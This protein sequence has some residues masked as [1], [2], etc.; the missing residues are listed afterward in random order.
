MNYTSALHI[1]ACLILPLGVAQAAPEVAPKAPVNL[2]PRAAISASGQF[3]ADYQ[4]R[5]VA[6]G[7]VPAAESHD[8]TGRAWCLSQANAA[9]ARLVFEWPAPVT[10]AEIV[11]YGRTAWLTNENFRQVRVLTEDAP[12]AI[13]EADL[14]PGH[15]PQHIRLPAPLTTRKLMLVF[16]RVD[17]G[18]NPGA[19]EICLFDAPISDAAL[20]RLIAPGDAGTETV[21]NE[22]PALKARLERGEFGFTKTLVVQRRPIR[23]SHVYT[24]HCEGLQPGGG[25][26]VYDL[27]SSNLTQLVDAAE[28]VVLD[29]DLSYDGREVLFSWM[30]D[31]KRFQVYRIGID[32]RG[33]KQLTDGDTYNFNACWLPDG[34]IAFLSTRR[35]AYAY[36]WSS[37]AGILHRMERDGEQVR[38]LSANYLND[39]TPSVLNDGRIVYSR[40]EYV[41]RPAIPIQSLW[42]INPDGTGLRAYYGNRVLS[43]A[44]FMEPRAVPGSQDVLCIM[45]AHNGPCRGAIGRLDRRFGE[46][47]QEA[48]RNLTPE[49]N[50]G[51]VDAGNGNAIR[52][53]YES[54]FPLDERYLFISKEGSLLIRDQEG[55]E[56]ALVLPRNSA[57]GWFNA[58]PVRPRER[59]PVVAGNIAPRNRETEWATVYVQDV[60]EGLGPS[61]QRGE[62]TEIRVVQEVPKPVGVNPDRRLFGFQFPVVS[63]GAT[64]AP[65]KIWGSAKVEA[66]GSASFRVPANLPVYFMALDAEGR[67]V[68]RMRSFV[69]LAPGEVQGCVGCHEHRGRTARLDARPAATARRAQEL[70]PPDWGVKGFSYAEVVQPVLD[71]HCIECHDARKR[72]KNVDLT[73]DKTD[74]F[75]VSYEC[76]ARMGTPAEDAHRGGFDMASF[77]SPYT[78]WIPTYNGTEQNILEIRPRTWGSPASKLADLIRTGH[79]DE[80]GKRR[81]DLSAAERRR[82]YAWIDCN[83]PYYPTSASRDLTTPGCRQ[84]YP[85]G[86]DPTLADVAKRRCADCHAGGKIPRTFYTRITNPQDNAFLLAPLAK[87]AGGTEACGRA[88]F[89]S[90]DDPDYRAILKTFDAVPGILRDRPRLEIVSADFVESCANPSGI[91]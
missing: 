20:A 3:S 29:C 11:Y 90:T 88:V 61:V 75:N 1:A 56:Q 77:R 36:C 57:Q 25:L 24:Y 19:S 59:P 83:V 4:P 91:P 37:P 87:S 58:V 23:P 18:P 44:T 15:G 62:I 73:G 16:P 53:P 78:S 27:A 71:R 41:D 72:P 30:R 65:K 85:A 14:K 69:H 54:V 76:L 7:K 22:S 2:A 12:R 6:D 42:T 82:I 10:V 13:V 68:Q 63:C 34:G 49:V 28:G 40:W 70:Q 84:V 55:S 46:N 64:Y 33:L 51:H 48:I 45:T 81:V 21:A 9:N 47:A 39:F 80:K 89:A 5:F 52:G 60:Y 79:P 43:P 50:I 35:S 17:G 38:Q 67:A 26:Y 66:D 31:M 8:D 32:G 74:L 86:L